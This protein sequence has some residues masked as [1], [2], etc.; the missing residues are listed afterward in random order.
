MWPTPSATAPQQFTGAGEVAGW[1]GRYRETAPDSEGVDRNGECGGAVR[2]V[3]TAVS[4]S[5]R[6]GLR[7]NGGAEAARDQKVQPSTLVVVSSVHGW[8]GGSTVAVAIAEAAVARGFSACVDEFSGPV[9]S[10]LG[11]ACDAELGVDLSGRW[12]VGRRGGVLIHRLADLGETIATAQPP[13]AGSSS[14][15]TIVDTG[16]SWPTVA[17]MLAA[18]CRTTGLAAVLRTAPLVLVCRATIPSL[19]QAE[20]VLNSF[21]DCLPALAVLGPDRW[22]GEVTA[23][24]GP[25]IT[26][27]RRQYRV[28]A[29]PLDKQLAIRGVTADPLPRT[30]TAAGRSL[31]QLST[32]P[33][34]RTSTTKENI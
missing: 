9:A 13:V 24:L 15:L 28:V 2:T 5:S 32:P 14:E 26:E 17:Q 7:V 27:L 6:K 31:L 23:S 18:P 34:A 29:V 1:F 25:R 33:P 12:R 19:R 3:D 10:G 4:L 11:V 8:A 22:P 21:S 20:A 30:V 16:W